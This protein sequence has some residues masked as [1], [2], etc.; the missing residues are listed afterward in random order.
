M[1]ASAALARRAIASRLPPLPSRTPSPAALAAACLRRATLPALH[2]SPS[3]TTTTTTNMQRQRPLTKAAAAKRPSRPSGAAAAAANPRPATHDAAAA[4]AAAS[5]LAGARAAFGADW[6]APATQM[7]AGVA[8]LREVLQLPPPPPEDPAASAPAGS[9]PQAAAGPLAEK[10]GAAAVGSSS[11]G[12]RTSGTGSGGRRRVVVVPDKDADGLS[13]GAILVRTAEMALRQAALE[14]GRAPEDVPVVLLVLPLGKGEN[15]HQPSVAARLAAAA[16]HALVL[17]DHGSRAAPPVLTRAAVRAAVRAAAG[18]GEE[19]EAAAGEGGGGGAAGTEEGGTEEGEGEEGVVPTLILDH[20]Q[21]DGFPEGAL[22]V[23]ASGCAPVAPSALL[24]WLLA[25]RLHPPASTPCAWLAVLGALGDLGE[26]EEGLGA[27]DRGLPMLAAAHR[28]GRKTHFKD[29][30]A[31]LNAARRSPDC[32]VSSAWAA[33]CAASAPLDLA[34]GAVP[35]A[36]GLRAAREALKEEMARLAPT[37]P[38]FSA[39]GAA[40]LLAV[41]SGWQV[42]PLIPQRWAFRLGSQDRTG[43]LRAVMAS[44]RGY[45]P[46]RVHFSARRAH[47]DVDLIAYLRDTVAAR[48]AHPA[49]A[50]TPLAGLPQRLGQDF[51]RG[52][53]E[54]SGGMVGTEEFG[55]LMLVLGFSP[56]DAYRAAG[57]P[58]PPDSD[59]LA[60]AVAEASRDLEGADDASGGG[61]GGGGG[62]G[63]ASRKKR[64]ASEAAAA[65]PRQRKLTAFFV[66]RE[67]AKAEAPAGSTD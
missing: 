3:T 19:R 35:G 64:T 1:L 55:L 16:P 48:C 36:A 32:D 59:R 54:A 25:G 30:V 40:A 21:P 45:T 44:N 18:A 37:P 41:E 60:A 47:K 33:L 13:A 26:G 10:G 2:P 50:A 66:K 39:D 38:R 34:R 49:L 27:F 57:L 31:L 52:H 61:A 14:A 58:P 67:G 63:A 42:H 12:G 8:F 4:A 62:S 20:H 53:P 23:S 43:R 28:E 22:A 11:G 5:P 24:T 51:A 7:D 17:L 29:A 56:V 9:R 65:D 46:G 6:P 15:V